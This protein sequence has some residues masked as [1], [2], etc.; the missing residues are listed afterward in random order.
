MIVNCSSVLSRIVWA[1]V[2]PLM[3]GECEGRGTA[4]RREARL[5]ASKGER[6]NV[7]RVLLPSIGRGDK[8]CES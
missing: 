6:P 1:T 8:D 7:A 4:G 5:G 3:S 2:V